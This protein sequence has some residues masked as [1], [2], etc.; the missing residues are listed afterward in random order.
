MDKHFSFFSVYYQTF[1]RMW[2]SRLL[3]GRSQVRALPESPANI[4]AAIRA[5]NAAR[6]G[7]KALSHFK[8]DAPLAKPDPVAFYGSGP[9]RYTHYP[10][11]PA[12]DQAA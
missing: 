10:A 2:C 4:R 3:S 6:N 1:A 5:S 12:K 8:A 11:L 9:N 7:S